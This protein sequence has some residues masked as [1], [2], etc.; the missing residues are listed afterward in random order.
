MFSILL[1][2]TSAVAGQLSGSC[3]D[4]AWILHL[5]QSLAASAASAVSPDSIRNSLASPVLNDRLLSKVL[6]PLSARSFNLKARRPLIKH[7]ICFWT[8]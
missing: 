7:F 4:R 3:M 2:P 6:I 5:I 1:S 8:L